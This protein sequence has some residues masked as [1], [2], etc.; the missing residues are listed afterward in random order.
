MPDI[1][2]PI[3]LRFWRTTA[4]R[5]PVRDW[6]RELSREDQQII[7]RDIAKVQFGWPVGLP[8]CRSLGEGIWE[9]RSKL[10]SRREARVLFGFH[11]ETLYALHAFFKKTQKTPPADLGVARARLREISSW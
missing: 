5:E 10:Q 6:L 11:E 4:G 2:R 9:I 8:L 3:P 7:G 1:I